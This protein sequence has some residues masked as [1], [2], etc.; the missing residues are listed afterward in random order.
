MRGK[1]PD[2]ILLAIVGIMLV[3]GLVAL[4]SASIMESQRDY[5]NA[6]AYFFHQLLFGVGGGSIAGFIAY[7][8]HYKKWRSF[9]LPMLLAAIALLVFVLIPSFSHE[10]GGA[11]RWMSFG[12]F[13]FQPSE[14]AKLSVIIYLAAWLEARQKSLR[15]WNE[16][17][18]PFLLILGSIGGL[19]LLQ[20]DVGTFGV[21]AL[22][23][24]IMF[25]GSG[26]SLVHMGAI[27]MLGIGLLFFLAKT[28]P[29]RMA[30]L[31]SFFDRAHDPLGIS[32]QINQA[33]LAIGSGGIFGVGLARS[34]QKYSSLPE[35]MTDS[36]FAVWSE[37]TGF[38]GA[39]FLISLFVALGFRGL[40]IAGRAHDRFG[41]LMA[42]GITFWIISQA[43]INIGS[44]VGFV[45][46]TGIPLPLASYGGSSMVVTLAG[47]GILLNISRHS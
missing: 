33:L 16:G 46:L 35:P 4:F 32:Y 34:I 45:P 6:Y 39:V 19:I 24:A 37:E 23:A 43:L 18:F 17:L 14:L 29:Y 26:A 36:I 20:P 22:V 27:G 25:F 13:S 3:T 7:K 30:R 44:M 12:D 41:K 1:K 28:E 31:F 5:G 21:I 11:R 8:V 40:R 42:L 2:Y 38:L 15:S 10:A 9:A 47:V